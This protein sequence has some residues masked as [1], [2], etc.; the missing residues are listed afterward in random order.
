[1]AEK[2]NMRV[3]VVTDGIYPFVMGGMQKHSYYLVKYLAHNNVQVEVA[4]CT[5]NAPLD[6][7]AF[8]SVAMKNVTF[9]SFEFSSSSRM[10]GHYIRANKTYSSLIYDYYKD[11]LTD[12]DIVYAQG[13]A[14]WRFSKER[15]NGKLLIP[16]VT[17]L[18]G[19][20][21]YQKA[22]NV[23]VKLQH[24]LL[25]PIAKYVSLH[26]DAVFSFGGKI[27]DILLQ[28]G[29]KQSSIL[30]CPIGI[31][32]HWIKNTPITNSAKRTFVFIGRNERRKGIIEL[33]AAL[34]K[35]DLKEAF[36][37]IFIGPI[38]IA[39][40]VTDS[41]IKYLGAVYDEQEIR[42]ALWKL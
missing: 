42:K 41:R 21:M 9:K 17:N 5:E 19:Y 22:P 38:A 34:R 15:Q 26:S 23:K 27:T 10:P 8:E 29:V 2:I 40:W 36:E 37:F 31:E 12:F 6:S 3:L 11:K 33:N 14:G 32:N 16:I 24:F 7:E 4:H 25:R 20:E 13:F 1:M 39:D 35:M 18:H 30:Q 28:I